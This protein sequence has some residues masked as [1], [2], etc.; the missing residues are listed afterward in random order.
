M[1]KA[2]FDWDAVWNRKGREDTELKALCG[3][4][5]VENVNIDKIAASIISD[6]EVKQEDRFLDIACG[7]GF[8]SS[9]ILRKAPDIIYVG[10]ER[11]AVIARKHR[12][13]LGNA[14]LNFSAH[15]AVFHD[16]FF[17]HC[18]C[19]S[20]FQYFPSHDYAKE[21]LRQM[22]R[23]ARR[24]YIGDLAIKSHDD[25]HLLYKQDEVVSWIMDICGHKASIKVTEGH[26]YT[27]R[28]NVIVHR[29]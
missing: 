17:S 16:D 24:A 22:L 14:V 11:S 26:F 1:N 28:F 6:L 10:T 20:A 7:G 27:T 25:S 3:Y 15:E 19:F 9:A 2:A 5:H 23:Q 12:Q 29:P 13:T 18:L 4:N 21:V 8:L